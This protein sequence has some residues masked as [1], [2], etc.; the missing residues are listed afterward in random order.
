M[1]QSLGIIDCAQWGKKFLRNLADFPEGATIVS[2]D[3]DPGRLTALQESQG[4]NGV[5]V[6]VA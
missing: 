1:R 4:Q 2:F 3:S 6:P 5:P